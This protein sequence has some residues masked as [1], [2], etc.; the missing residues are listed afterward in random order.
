MK[1]SAA[2]GCKATMSAWP[3]VRK[4]FATML[5]Y[6]IMTRTVSYWNQ[7]TN[8]YKAVW[9]LPSKRRNWKSIWQPTIQALQ[10]LVVLLPRTHTVVW[11]TCSIAVSY[12]HLDVYKRQNQGFSQF[13]YPSKKFYNYGT[14]NGFPLTAVN[15]NALFVTH[16]GEVFLG[17]I[18]GMISFWEKK[19]HFTPKSY[20]II[21]SRLLVN[22][23]EVVP[24]DESGILEQ[25]ICHTPEI[26]LKA[27]Q[28]MFSIE[29][30][31][32]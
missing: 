20:N 7:T 28:S 14:E 8:V 1:S 18:Q 27:N 4:E 17:G 15:E 29:Y 30:R 10:P 22:G 9:V 26:S 6:L 32:V 21:L 31:C 2:H 24:G 25:S 3:V 12:T 16:D 5:L 11:I 23:K 13:D 19:L